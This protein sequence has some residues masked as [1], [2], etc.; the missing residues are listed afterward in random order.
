[1]EIV[2]SEVWICRESSRRVRTEAW[3]PEET[4]F[5]SLAALLPE[6]GGCV[7][8]AFTARIDEGRLSV[9][10]AFD[11]RRSVAYDGS[12]SITGLR[13]RAFP[14]IDFANLPGYLPA[15]VFTTQHVG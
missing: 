12:P 8:R 9:V 13:L 3:C 7:I 5:F 6:A 11:T 14:S 2:A 10:A 4:L 1:M 15:K